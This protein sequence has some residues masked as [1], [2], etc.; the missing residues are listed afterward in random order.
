MPSVT[1]VISRIRRRLEDADGLH[2][3]D[4]EVIGAINEAK[5]DLYDYVFT[6]NRDV[7]DTVSVNFT[8]TA[9]KMSSPLQD[10]YGSEDLGTYDI[11][12]VSSTPTTDG[13]SESNR[14][15]PLKRINFEELYRHGSAY[16]GFYE[17]YANARW[18]GGGGGS[19]RSYHRW[20]QQGFT[21]Y[22]DPIPK[23]EVQL[24]FEIIKRFKEFDEAGTQNS[25][26][27]FP[28]DEAQFTR[29]A[30]IIEYSAA[31]VLKGRSDENEDPLLGQLQS[32][33]MLLNAWLDSKSNTGTAR[34]VI[35]G[36]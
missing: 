9:D 33:Y 32:K 35:N 14:P 12:L 31:L 10:I 30:R 4:T 19:A 1:T 24:R 16:S 27:L 36:Y 21:V 18:A 7:F 23:V 17:D 8:W 13:I 25:S 29:W 15:V 5:N 11:I 2:W 26:D 28:N 22:I 20:A 34:V 6:R 3:P